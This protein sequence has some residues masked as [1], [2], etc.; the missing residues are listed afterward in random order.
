M[1]KETEVEMELQEVTGAPRADLS[2]NVTRL[3]RA[4]LLT[5]GLAGNV[6]TERL[7]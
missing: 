2:E 5:A 1:K 7:R 6:T 3:F 4:S